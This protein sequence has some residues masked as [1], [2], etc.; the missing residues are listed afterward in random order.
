MIIISEN[1]ERA[2][3]IGYNT[4]RYK[5]GAFAISG[6]FASVAGGLFAGYQ[7]SVAPENS[8]NLF[9]T[10][11]AL[12]GRHRGFGTLVGSLYGQLIHVSLEEILATDENGLAFYL[13][14][15]RPEGVLMADIGGVTVSE[16]VDLLLA[17]RAELYI[18]LVFVLF[19]L[20]VPEG[21]LGAFWDRVGKPVSRWRARN[22][23][24]TSRSDAGSVH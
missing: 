1:E 7:R 13:R 16:V 5:L 22:S 18:G 17:G 15:T 19:V 21:I 20:L 2:K 11:D 6:F 4:H 8:L 12:L 10:A 9:V 3:A 14:E 23:T 24:A